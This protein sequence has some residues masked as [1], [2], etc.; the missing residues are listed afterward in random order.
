MQ[1]KINAEMSGQEL[2]DVFVAKLKEVNVAVTPPSVKV[3]VYSEK[4]EKWLEFKPE[5][6]KLTYSNEV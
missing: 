2:V 6:V 1:I 4:G 3:Q 5:N